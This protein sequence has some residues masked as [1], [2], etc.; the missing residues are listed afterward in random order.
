M[1]RALDA[2]TDSQRE[3]ELMRRVRS[4]ELDEAGLE[5]WLPAFPLKIQLQTASPCNAACQMCPWP[6]TRE[7]L[8]QGSMSGE[9]F[10]LFEEQVR[11]QPV[12]RLSL[13]LMNEP[14]IDRRLEGF[15]RRLKQA[16]PRADQ[17]IYT[18]GSLLSGERAEALAEAGL[19]ELSISVIGFES[20]SYR[21][22]MGGLSFERALQRLTEVGQR[23]AAGRLGNMRVRVVGLD[24]PEGRAGLQAFAQ[25][26]G[27][28]IYLNP[29][30]NR[31]GNVAAE[32]FLDPTDLAARR[33]VFRACQR[34][35][36]KAYVL[37][38]GQVVLCNCDWE[39]STIVGDIRQQTL[40]EIWR[41]PAL[42]AIRR[43]H[44]SA[45]LP[46]DSLCARCDYPFIE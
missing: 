30:T 14:L 10:D 45:R 26:T 4:G 33:G 37:Y 40:A 41:G 29:L 32:D 8:P 15:I 11:G 42:N 6:Q 31:A 39:R 7:T 44:I 36:V 2:Q 1:S 23:L 43:A 16:L 35:F 27:L 46:A 3:Q 17:V 38:T 20:E 9:V 12:E 24:F 25:Q 13:F 19:D 21:R 34:P 5:H 22:L 28:P 18:N